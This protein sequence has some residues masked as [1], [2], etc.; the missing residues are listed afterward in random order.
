MT[1]VLA[2]FISFLKGSS[3]LRKVSCST[4]LRVRRRV[5]KAIDTSISTPRWAACAWERGLFCLASPPYMGPA[6]EEEVSHKLLTDPGKPQKKQESC[7]YL[8]R[9]LNDSA[10]TW[11]YFCLI[12][13]VF[14]CFHN[15]LI[16]WSCWEYCWQSQRW[17][18]QL[19]LLLVPNLYLHSWAVAASPC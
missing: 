7:Q 19:W 17:G 11:L 18:S 16:N 2:E 3:S 15:L 14:P 9:L 6:S 13:D 10:G 1:F 8:F 4:M 12:V 5:L